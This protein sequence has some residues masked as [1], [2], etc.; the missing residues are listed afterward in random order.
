MCI[1][2]SILLLIIDRPSFTVKKLTFKRFLFLFNLDYCW[3]QILLR[4]LIKNYFYQSCYSVCDADKK[5][6]TTGRCL[7][8]RG[9]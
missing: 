1:S 4:E 7:D 2:H 6:Q 5:Q 8:N 3:I 9:R